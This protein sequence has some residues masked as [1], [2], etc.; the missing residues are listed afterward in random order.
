M[1]EYLFVDLTNEVVDRYVNLDVTNIITPINVDKLE[2]LLTESQYDKDKTN[3]LINGFRCGFDIGYR[4]PKIRRDFSSNIPIRVGSKVELWNKVM[5]EVKL[6]RYAGP[7]AYEDIPFNNLMQSPIGL[8]PKDG[9]RQ[10]RLIFHLS[11]DFGPNN[12]SLNH[13]TPE[14]LC[15]VRYR[16]LDH[17]IANCIR[18]LKKANKRTTLFYGKSDVHSAFRLVP[19]LPE[20]FCWL[21]MKAQDP[22]SGIFYYFVDKCLPFEASISCAIFQA[23]SDAFAHILQFL[24][25]KQIPETEGDCL[26]NYLDDFLFIAIAKM[27]CDRLVKLFL[28]LCRDIGC[29]IAEKTEWGSVRIIFLGILLD[30]KRHILAVPQEKC[31]KTIKTLQIVMDRKTITIKQLQQLTGLLNFLCKAFF[32]GRVFICRMYD[33]MKGSSGVELKSYHHVRVNNDLKEDCQMWLKF[34]LSSK[35]ANLYRPFID[36]NVF[37]SSEM[38]DFYT[39]SSANENF[40]YG[41]VFEDRWIFNQWEPGFVAEYS[42]S[43]EYLELVALCIGILSWSENPKLNNARVIIFCDNQAVMHMVNNSTSRCPR[44]MELLRLLIL[45]NLKHNR[46]VFVRFVPSK[47]NFRADCLSRM[48][49]KEF[50]EAAPYMRQFP[51]RATKAIWPIS[52][53]WRDK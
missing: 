21:V 6:K 33:K 13:Y 36:L 15:R 38:L 41:C 18:L 52:Q 31:I 30:G 35:D 14:E 22:V 40:G 16:D 32:A 49:I 24:A 25:K 8:V 12:R 26:T 44:C 23:F 1:F 20:Q 53:F 48:K 39:D 11:Y 50:R 17:A 51:D 37:E 28:D 27:L 43:I 45:D 4:G 42:P 29:P 2:R 7:F 5:K 10:T 9:G 46:R 47:K 3:Y 34:L 19:L